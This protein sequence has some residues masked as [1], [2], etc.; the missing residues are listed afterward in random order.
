[1]ADDLFG[2]PHR[3]LVRL[4]DIGRGERHPAHLRGRGIGKLAAAMADIHIPQSGQPVDI[5][6][7]V[8]GIEHRSLALDDDQRLPVVVG[9]VQGM[10]QKPPIGRD[11][12][13]GAV[14]E[15]L[16][17]GWALTGTLTAPPAS[18]Q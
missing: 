13:A 7:A 16:L 1:M 3:R 2:E 12:F 4:A 15:L 9:M 10:H 18:R 17:E 14:H 5:A 8:R 6:A 11:Q